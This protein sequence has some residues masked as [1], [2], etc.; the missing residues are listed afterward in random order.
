MHVGE[1]KCP[2]STA[3]G[4]KGAAV[5]SMDGAEGFASTEADGEGSALYCS[6]QQRLEMKPPSTQATMT[7]L[8]RSKLP[9][10]KGCSLISKKKTPQV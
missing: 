1:V 2:H 6:T 3:G 8:N 7:E 5:G 9:S 4:I 10:P